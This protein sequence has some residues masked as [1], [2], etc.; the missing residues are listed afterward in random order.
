MTLHCINL[1]Q[2]VNELLST[3]SEVEIIFLLHKNIMQIKSRNDYTV[4]P[5]MIGTI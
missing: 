1:Q 2:K 4:I 5:L 3:F